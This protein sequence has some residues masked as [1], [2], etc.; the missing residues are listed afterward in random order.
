MV[1]KK[2]VYRSFLL[3]TSLGFSV[4]APVILCIYAAYWVKRVYG[5]NIFL[6][7]IIFGILSGILSA[8]KSVNY[9][10]KKVKEED[11]KILEER[12]EGIKKQRANNPKKKSR[13]FKEDI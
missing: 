4:V 5:L 13:I 12:S 6:A 1:Y 11:K 7:A 3:V 10:L 2:S 9:F 8:Y